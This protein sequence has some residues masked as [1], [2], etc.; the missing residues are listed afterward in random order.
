MVFASHQ[1]LGDQLMVTDLVLEV[2]G[3]VKDEA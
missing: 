1:G 2:G 3:I